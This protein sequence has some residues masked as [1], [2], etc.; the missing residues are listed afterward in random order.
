MLR[1]RFLKL[2]K[3]DNK[4]INW[5]SVGAIP[6]SFGRNMTVDVIGQLQ[7]PSDGDFELYFPGTLG[8]EILFMYEGDT[9]S[10]TQISFDTSN[11]EW[12]LSAR[13]PEAIYFP[14]DFTEVVP[15]MYSDSNDSYY[16]IPI[17]LF[18]IFLGNSDHIA[19]RVQLYKYLYHLCSEGN[20]ITMK[21]W[22]LIYTETSMQEISSS[23]VLPLGSN[24]I[25]QL[26]DKDIK[27]SSANDQTRY[28]ILREN[29]SYV[30][31]GF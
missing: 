12:Q 20:T 23:T 1:R 7:L 30:T 8:D 14:D 24:C 11:N 6:I 18:P 27:I 31:Y 4:I 22:E 28:L 13:I 25:A 9:I 29:G 17:C 3:G 19:E 26:I 2:K 16:L 21:D 10:E 15:E 5:L